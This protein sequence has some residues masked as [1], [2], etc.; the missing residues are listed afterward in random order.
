MDSDHRTFPAWLTLKSSLQTMAKM[1]DALPYILL[2][3][4]RKSF[5]GISIFVLTDV[6]K[7]PE[8]DLV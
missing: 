4:N 1:Y 2:W 8:N 6:S 7:V 5:S 3:F